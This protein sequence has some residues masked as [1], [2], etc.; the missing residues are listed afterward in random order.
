[1]PHINYQARELAFK[2]VYY[3]P[4][5]S[6]KTTNLIHIHS[7]LDPERR[8]D[9][10]VLDT[11]EE[12]TLFFD[13]FPLALGR[14]GDFSVRFNMYT[15][16]GQVY[17]EASRRLILD[18]ADGIVFVADSQPNRLNENIQS[19]QMLQESLTSYG[20]D[21]KEFPLVLQYNK[22][23]LQDLLPVGTLESRLGLN[24]I[25]VQEAVATAGTGVMETIRIASRAVIEKFQL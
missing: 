4:G 17:Y 5:L 21:W 23:D 9:I 11:E 20:V 12:R 1:M 22:R 19:F 6:G 13:F 15:V 14:I 7:T 10:V 2:I 25:P 24:G 8:G 18:G 16:P 3:G